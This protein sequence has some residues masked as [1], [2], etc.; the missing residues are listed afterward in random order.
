MGFLDGRFPNR[1]LRYPKFQEKPPL[2][3][4][5]E[6]E[7]RIKAGGLTEEQ[8]GELWDALYLTLPEIEKIL[9]H[10]KK[11][12]SQPWVYPLICFAAHTGG[13]RAEMLRVLV[14]DVDFDGHTVLIR[15]KKKA[16][17]RTTTRRVPLTPFLAGVLKDWLKVH[18]GG[19]YLFCQFEV[20]RSK[21][22]RAV[23]MPITH[24][25]AHDH[26]KR[27]LAATKWKVI[28]GYHIFRH[29]FISL[30]ASKGTDQRLIDEWTGH[31]TEE[32][33]RRYRHLF[34][35]TQQ[36]AILSVFGK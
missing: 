6:I 33:R 15:E 11:K 31:C 26:F 16:K 25:E 13:R 23:P 19:Q 12:A 36:Q 21:T 29:S 28:R 20:V 4:W 5:E 34:P 24:D 35:T 7:R 27:T 10:V 3:T 2:H 9:A 1:G 17:G 22:K 32:Q 14:S 8:Q 30:C 18:P